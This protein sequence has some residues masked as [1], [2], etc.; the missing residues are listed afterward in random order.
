MNKTGK[1]T[2]SKR[3]PLIFLLAVALTVFTGGNAFSQHYLNHGV[4]DGLTPGEKTALVHDEYPHLKWYEVKNRVKALE[5]KLP[6]TIPEKSGRGNVRARLPLGEKVNLIMEE[7]KNLM[8][9]DIKRIQM[10]ANK[11]QAVP[12]P[13]KRYVHGDFRHNL[14][15]AE[16]R[17][18][19]QEES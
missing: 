16:K 10:T 18:L 17:R 13:D 14:S 6:Y 19:I 4:R 2:I 7:N 9:H 15:D 3:S 5:K 12:H 1:Q 8:H 11:P